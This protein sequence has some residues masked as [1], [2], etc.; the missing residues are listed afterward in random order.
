MVHERPCS[1]KKNPTNSL[2]QGAGVP[3]LHAAPFGVEVSFQWIF[4]INETLEMSP[5]QYS[6]QRG[7]YFLT[8]LLKLFLENVLPNS[9]PYIPKIGT[10]FAYR[11]PQYREG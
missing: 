10:L 3:S 1:H 5:G 6:P 4:K 8:V 2:R 7:E 9:L 11:V